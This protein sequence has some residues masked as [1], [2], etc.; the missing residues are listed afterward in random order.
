MKILARSL[1]IGMAAIVCIYAFSGMR[2]PAPVAKAVISQI[3]LCGSLAFFDSTSRPVDLYPGLGDLTFQ[4]ST[5]NK[6]VQNY[7]DQ[8]LR[9]IY[10][11]NHVEALRSF[12]EASR[13]EPTNAMTY[14]GQALAL[15]PNLN[16]WNP[17]DREAEA[18]RV[19][20]KALELA[21]KAPPIELDF[22]KAMAA[23]YDG[24]AHDDRSQLNEAYA[25]AMEVVANKYP[26]HPEALTLYADAVMNTMPWN[27]WNAD[28]T[29]KAPTSKA[30]NALEKVLSKNPKHPG[31]HHLYIHLVEASNNPADALASAEFLETAMPASG[32][33]VH[34][35]A[36]IY[37]RTG[38]YE[39]SNRSN[40][41]AIQ[42]D[43][44]FLSTSEDQ[45]MYRIGYY[46]HN[47]DFL[48]YGSMMNGQTRHA[49][50]N[51][52]KL[53]YQLKPME[54]MMPMYYDFF[55]T[56]PIQALV[57]FGKWNEV[58]ALPQPDDSYLQSAIVSHF[59]RGLAF[60]RKERISEAKMELTKLESYYA[61]DTLHSIY[62]AFNSA[63]QIASI[64]IHIL[65]GELLSQSGK[66]N[67]AMAMY[68]KAI[69][70]EDTLRY[71]EPPDWRL[72]SRHYLG[73]ALLEAGKFSEAQKVFE[74]DLRRNPENGWSLKGLMI[75][76][77]KQ[78]NT[79]QLE[80]VSNRFNTTWKDADVKIATSRY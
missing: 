37:I 16:D 70:A 76:L 21:K 36:H 44:F 77:E 75:C 9:L 55:Q 7:F 43:E 18:F 60:V 67:E 71:N 49:L 28:G 29:P 27:Y 48:I 19:I 3:S 59:A 52:M 17:A 50:T 14:W 1:S 78:G 24:A 22:I 62:G 69:S 32:H 8:G 41:L 46:P 38:N 47:I 40:I 31:A 35:P 11:F 61:W 6:V 72:P 65:K 23:R 26:N 12:R 34:M 33:L 57:R 73:A 79:S 56:S 5:K 54:K 13:L 15:G 63:H 80:A 45:G 74:E 68:E 20:N 10:A 30:R 53:V 25:K 42:A 51:S 58:L 66:I 64:A 4:I 39:R 2:K